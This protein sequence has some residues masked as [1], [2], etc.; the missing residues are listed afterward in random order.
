MAPTQDVMP[1]CLFIAE[2]I[3]RVSWHS[4]LVNGALFL[5][6]LKSKGGQASSSWAIIITHMWP[7]VK[8]RRRLFSLHRA[9]SLS[10]SAGAAEAAL[11][12]GPST[13][14]VNGRRLGYLAIS[15]I[16]KHTSLLTVSQMLK[17]LIK[18]TTI[19]C[20]SCKTMKPKPK[21]KRLPALQTFLQFN[22]SPPFFKKL[23]TNK[24]LSS[25][26]A[27]AKNSSSFSSFS[28]LTATH[29]SCTFHWG[30]RSF[31]ANERKNYRNRRKWVVGYICGGTYKWLF[32]LG[33]HCSLFF[34]FLAYNA[35]R[36]IRRRR[37]V[38][39]CERN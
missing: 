38:R 1:S 36:R 30:I 19:N 23:H 22:N 35:T 33:K 31:Y 14:P 18:L 27:L 28:K 26:L 16:P 15:A 32:R 24:V 34:C 20:K 11:A 17:L 39:E 37:R 12:V 4:S 10:C 3:E 6:F 25:K 2:N 21:T 9:W 5:K 7:M 8:R 13:L 29:H